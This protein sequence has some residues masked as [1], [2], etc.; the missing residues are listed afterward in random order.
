MIFCGCGSGRL[1]R[2]CC[3]RLKVPPELV[4]ELISV[5]RK[6]AERQRSYGYGR[7]IIAEQMGPTRFVAVGNQI[8]WS[9]RWKTF[10]DFLASYIKSAMGDDWGDKELTKPFSDQHPVV[11]WYRHVCEHQKATIKNPG[12][13]SEAIATAP[14]MAYLSLSYDIYSLQHHGLLQELLLKR[15]RHKD[16]FQGARYEIFVAASF[17]RAGFLVELEDE[18]DS[19]QTHCE[20]SAK[21]TATGRWCS[22]E[23]KSRRRPGFLGH[24][25]EPQSPD[26]ISADV[27]RLLQSA[28][29]KKAKHPRVVFVDVNMP[30]R[31]E[32]LFE[33][34]WGSAVA[35]QLKRLEDTQRLADPWP[36]AIIVFTN[37]P[38]HYVDASTPAPTP[39]IL[40]T[41]M[42]LAE[43]MNLPGINDNERLA[44]MKKE[45]PHVAA[46]TDSL[47]HHTDIP[48]SF[49]SPEDS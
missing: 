43:F 14:V 47:F 2:A 6:D 12:E 20:F 23:A 35:A 10:H 1:A 27:Y 19:T 9:E 48:S 18:S 46:L 3:A 24:R 15:L 36:P 16:Q 49:S 33:G 39:T 31:A 21:H 26:E 7:P 34:G 38:Y 37:H 13:V 22:V 5:E 29:K 17:V 25:G 42:N 45:F 44:Q 28:L 8:H 4:K 41:G 40:V 11:Q 30:P 32:K